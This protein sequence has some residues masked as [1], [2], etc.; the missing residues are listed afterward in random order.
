MGGR[1]GRTR[2]QTKTPANGRPGR[3]RAP[4]V[5]P[6]RPST[7][8][9]A[10][11]R[12]I[13]RTAARLCD[14]T[15][16]HI[17]RVE[18]DHLQVVSI[19]GSVPSVRPIGRTVPITP[20][21]PGG[22]AVLERKTI[23]LRDI[24]TPAVQRRY[25][26]FRDLR[27]FP[28]RTI[29]AVP[30]LRDGLA[31]GLITIRR[32]RVRPFTAKQIELLRTFADQAAIA[33]ENER[34]REQLE[35]RNRDLTTSLDQQTA[36]SD[37]LRVISGSPT[38]VQPVFDTIVESAVRLCD[39][40]FSAAFKFDGTL[41]HLAAHHNFTAEALEVFHRV[42]PRAPSRETQVSTAILDR[43]SVEVRDFEN[44]PGVSPPSIS[45]ARALGYRSN[46][47]VPMLRDGNPI[48]AIA[49][50]RAAAGPF[51]VKQVELLRTFAD[52]AVIAIE[53][54]RLFREL[55][56]RN[57]DL[58]E[59][60]EQQTATS[61]VLKVISRST[62]DLQPVLETLIENASRLCGADSGAVYRFDGE[63]QRLAAA[64]NI[65]PELREYVEQH[66]LGPGSGTAVGRAVLERRA[67]HIHDALADPEYTYSGRTFGE[68]RTILGIPMLREGTPVGV[69]SV[70]RAKVLPFT[71]KQIELVTTFA[72]QAVIAI[73]NVR[74]FKELEAR[75][76]DLTESL[77]QQTATGE[78]LSVI[79][80]SPTDVQPVF[81]TI[82]ANALALCNGTW[83]AVLRFDGDVMELVS[84]HNLSDPTGIEAV[85]RAFPRRPSRGGATDR[86]ILTRTVAHIPDVLEDPEYQHLGMAQAAGYRSQLS[87]PMLREGQPLG[88]ITVAGASP[89]TFSEQQVNL[90]R[91]FADQ[92]VIAI[93]NVRLFRELQ[94][95]NRDLT[96]TLEQQTA[97]GEILR[98]ISSSPTNVQP[99]FDTIVRSAV[100]LC[101]GLYGAVNMF[102][103]EMILYPSA[104]YNYTPEAMAAVERM[105]PRRPNRQQLI[106]RAVLSR[107]VAQIPD[108]LNDPEYAP[109]IALA[110]GWRSALAAPMLRDGHPV[111]AILVTRAQIGLFSER[112]MELLKI[113]ADQ[114]VIAIENVR[115]FQELE[116]RNRDLT[117][118]LDQQTATS[119]VL[120]VISRSTF[121]LQPV[122]K[123]L[124]E[125]AVRLCGANSGS[126][127]RQDGDLYRLAVASGMTPEA[128]E[129]HK[130][131]PTSLNRE[132]ATGR[133]LLERRAVHLHDA[134]AD[135]E[136]RWAAESGAE[137]RTV[138]AVPMVREATVL[139][140][141]LLQRSEIQPFTGKQIELV[142]TFADQAVIAIENVRLFTEL[143]VRNRDLTEALEQQTATSEVLRAIS[144][145]P[146]DLRPIYQTILRSVTRL[147]EAKIAA[148]FLYDGEVL[149][150]AA[151]EGAT[152]EFAAQLDTQ[153]VRP[154]RE[155]PT[156]RAALE[157]QVVHVPDVLADP[158]YSPTRAHGAENP[159][160]VLAVPMRR[161]GAVIGVITTWRREVRPF[162]ERQVDLVKTFADQAVIA[163]ENVR[164][165]KELEDRNKD[166]TEALEQ[167]TATSEVLKVI[168]R[169]TFD[170]QPVLET[171]IESAVRLCGADSSLVYRQDGDLYRVVA[172]C[173]TTPAF[174]E[175]AKKHPMALN[176]ESATG[177][178]ILD[179]RV[180]HIPDAAADPEY[181]WAG[182]QGAAYP[183]ILAV[184]M[185]REATVI[186]VITVQRGQV[187]PFSDKQI[188][189]V[190]TFADQAVIAIENVRLFQELGARNRDLT[191][192]LEQ[193]TATSEVL[194][195]I[196]RST[197]DLQPVLETLV[198]SAVRLCGA[199]SGLIVRQDGNLYRVV[200]TCGMTRET[201][202]VHKKYPMSLNRESATG[203]ALLERRVIHIHDAMADPEYRWAE[204]ERG[205]EIRTTLADV[206]TILAVP[207]LREATVIGV[208][209][210]HRAEVH[211]FSDKQIELVTTFADQAVIAIE[212]VRLFQEL[213]ARTRDLSRSVQELTA[214]GEV[215]RA[216]SATL[217]VETV[218]Q[219]VVS[220][221]S[222]LAAADGG[223]IFEYDEATQEFRL[224]ATHDYEPEVVTALQA[225]PLRMGEGVV[226][227]A[228]ERREPMQVADIAEEGSYRSRLRDVL[229][230]TGY[231][232]VLA[233]PLVREGQVIGALTVSRK[234]P[235]EFPQ[236]VIELLRTF[237][238]QSA[239]AIQNARLFRE[240]EA[241]SQELEVASRHKSEFLANMS[242]ELRTPLNAIIGY[243]E[244]LQ[245]EARD[246]NAESFVPDLQRINAA[247]KHLLEL[248]N[249]VLDLSKIEAG[250]M[251]LY[252]ESFEVG[253]LVRDVAAVLEPLA[254][255]NAN[256]LEV[257][258][259]PDIGAMRADLTKLRQTLFNLL[260][261]A[262]KFTE[263]GVVSVAV[264]REPTAD[265]D[266]IL[267]AVSDTGIGMTPEQMA[268]LFEE[269]GQVDASTTRRYGG[270]GLGLAL[271]RRLC[272][273]M[274]GDITVASEPGH[275]STFTIRLPAEVTESARETPAP[276]AREAAPAGASTVLVIDDDGAVRDLMSRF[277]GK[278]GFRVVAAAGGEEGLRLARELQ[279][280][281]I[282]LDVLMPGMDGWSVLAALKADATLADIPVVMLTMLDDRNLGYALGAADYLTKPIDRERLVAV[283]GRHRRDLPVLVVDDDPDFRDL[284]RRM[285]ER[286]G[287]TVIEA[288]NGRAALDRLRDT[289]PGVILLDLMM[290]EMDG[291]DFV[292]A[293]R[294]DAAW[295]SVPIVV[296]TA[297][298]L[299]PEEHERLNGSVAR[300]LQK[301]ALS[302]ETL[303]GEVRDLVA[304]SARHSRHIGRTA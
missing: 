95:R 262:C 47:T 122:L 152:P 206:R 138:L 69:F 111:G 31:V 54:V 8:V 77:E 78:I 267:F 128:L 259:A 37:I 27:E 266:S 67:V 178:A 209:L 238:T 74:L 76:R 268:R 242:H 235:G 179:H 5:E 258:C 131:Y 231:R 188:E 256:R 276:T 125:S 103:G 254:L 269:F 66:P 290:P 297:K 117:E 113:F 133:A 61:E 68:Y 204:A 97:T 22:H 57:Q 163:I 161:E 90:L 7:D 142:T 115:L 146:S 251:E 124:I 240:L 237:A 1:L 12:A 208:I 166:L 129:I 224:R 201:I 56:A 171:L 71:D 236:E 150:T 99:V 23:H 130:K 94:V 172:A 154:S 222:Q 275:G 248:I 277:L 293:V 257:E 245:E 232:A 2:G 159:R 25:P 174:I 230:R 182:Q 41:I 155:T 244:M 196:S 43:T 104:N 63:L 96:E 218:L 194:K 278:E 153:R 148:L 228:A 62:F 158:E 42:Y 127:V 141:I 83:S 220:H 164:L 119:E 183:T 283:L 284:T 190:T 13:A 173:G 294:A 29:L 181:K 287:Y 229:L 264:T 270:T 156:R 11:L 295:R 48:G 105:Y 144:T 82:A 250:K 89:G 219:T 202:E 20:D 191:E 221:A 288:D 91:V 81:D 187:Q 121:D 64:H 100:R 271:S 223:A 85:R 211:P 261:N 70:Q 86:A 6:A 281:V 291:F 149:R 4:P 193:Q 207:M 135:P 44:D 73:E 88:A 60:L 101:D 243:S 184:P 72:D 169:S 120:K 118:A 185:L 253:S 50:A 170:L 205:V 263:R 18:G 186:G 212:N 227:S 217:D 126:I 139:G 298:N 215:S 58:T 79:S 80:S 59:A 296:I 299:S 21:L 241:K 112:Q 200:V 10:I 197:F 213:E 280:D 233:V 225:M 239:L 255:K 165:F 252:L 26:G 160:T 301:G 17:Y 65:S 189:L 199:N 102:D 36:T 46:L 203:R 226:G 15:G 45:L 168:S 234:A 30:L 180:V 292:T 24:R 249:G 289:V 145:S 274:G 147:C 175:L 265:G 33:L 3:R 167:Q 137:V 19:H 32:M 214:L 260:S 84:L 177:R 38:D 53:N 273:M 285:L 279:P 14:A 157:G 272:R 302:R 303:L 136:Y 52:Q 35:G 162:S 16:A 192:A 132:S 34:L 300:V 40:L 39:G 110:G 108:V 210:L 87:V 134:M 176:R 93:E 107:T 304:A 116:T 75:N 143:E 114:A 109:D 151:H 216:V 198:E 51:S 28:F 247:G 140:V 55:E 282:T 92:A 123:T 98:V 195:V 49:V 286:E 9:P 246:Q 106:G